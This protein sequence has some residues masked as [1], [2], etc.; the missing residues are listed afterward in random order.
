MFDLTNLPD[1]KKT[2]GIIIRRI[3]SAAA[4]STIL[5]LWGEETCQVVDQGWANQGPRATSGTFVL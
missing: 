5:R 2:C 3:C 4:L 1:P